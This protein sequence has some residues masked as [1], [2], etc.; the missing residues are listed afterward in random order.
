MSRRTAPCRSDFLECELG[1]DAP[2]ETFFGQVFDT[3]Y[4]D[5]GHDGLAVWMGAA[6]QEVPTA[7]SLA[8]RLSPW[9]D[10]GAE[11]IEALEADRA[12]EPDW[13]PL[14]PE[15]VAWIETLPEIRVD[16]HMPGS[17]LRHPEPEL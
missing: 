11:L 10:I 12:A 1:W 4:R 15:V 14:D 8:E 3:R 17:Q 6:P 5:D 7:A 9:V 16:G 2:L 13:P